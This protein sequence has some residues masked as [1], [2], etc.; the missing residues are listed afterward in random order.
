MK[1][2]SAA[3]RV[4]SRVPPRPGR[5]ESWDAAA[6]GTKRAVA[7]G[8]MLVASADPAWLRQ[9]RPLLRAS[10]TQRVEAVE[11][12]GAL[13]KTLTEHAP[14]VLLLDLAGGAFSIETVWVVRTLSP[15]SRTILLASPPDD[16]EAVRALREGAAGYAAKDT[17]PD[18]LIAAIG[19]VR[20][21]GTWV[22][23]RTML[24]L[25]E[26]FAA[27]NSARPPGTHGRVPRLTRRES[28]VAELTAS[29]APNKEIAD[30][31]NIEERT[32]KAHLSNIFQKLGLSSRLQL[33]S[34]V[35]TRPKVQ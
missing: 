25:I 28:E 33:A 5:T 2:P 9:L 32:V 10:G 14:Q 8:D 35:W 31:L 15:T 12:Q 17:E 23:P 6:P 24:R 22:P 34:Y 19:L 26:D 16:G 29:G 1:T 7:Y 18:L 20:Q 3:V 11:D 13:E 27:R 21:G 30:R 4:L